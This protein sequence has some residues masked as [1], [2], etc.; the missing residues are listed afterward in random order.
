M[1]V[2]LGAVL[3]TSAASWLNMQTAYALWHAQR[4]VDTSKM[5]SLKLAS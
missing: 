4:E 1:A 5:K 3:G 2:R